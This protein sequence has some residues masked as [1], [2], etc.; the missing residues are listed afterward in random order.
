MGERRLLSKKV[1]KALV[2]G[3]AQFRFLKYSGFNTTVY[4]EYWQVD[5]NLLRKMYGVTL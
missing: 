3:V 2:A 1:W 5:G 4:W